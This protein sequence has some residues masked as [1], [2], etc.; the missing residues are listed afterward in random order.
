MVL[1][2]VRTDCDES[3]LTVDRNTWPFVTSREAL[4]EPPPPAG[5]KAQ[6]S[7]VWRQELLNSLRLLRLGTSH[8]HSHNFP[9]LP[10][11]VTR[12]R[13]CKHPLVAFLYDS[14]CPCSSV[15]KKKKVAMRVVSISN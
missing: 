10:R 5:T 13:K 12:Q 4:R 9:Q 2:V 11:E 15:Y 1:C 7:Y 6:S 14:G 8:P 3:S